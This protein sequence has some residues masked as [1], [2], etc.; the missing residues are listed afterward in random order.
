M[1]DKTKAVLLFAVIAAIS[2]IKGTSGVPMNPNVL[3]PWSL[4]ALV[5]LASAATIVGLT[6]KLRRLRREP[7]VMCGGHTHRWIDRLDD[8][9]RL[10]V[11]SGLVDARGMEQCLARFH[12]VESRSSPFGD[13]I[14]A[15]SAFLVTHDVLTCWQIDKLRRGQYKGFYDIP[16]Y[17]LLDRLGDVAHDR[18][19]THLAESR[20]GEVVVLEVSHSQGGQTR[21]HRVTKVVG[22]ARSDRKL[23][24]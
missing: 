20:E 9:V 23:P 14:T 3:L 22:K 2:V 10:T 11:D 7:H 21:P 13:T 12:K 15:F 17:R 8:F 16:D 18:A 19:G 6:L 5:S 24:Q 4:L 1:S